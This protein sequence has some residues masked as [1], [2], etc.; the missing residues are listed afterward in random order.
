LVFCSTFFSAAAV[1]DGITKCN[2]RRYSA[3]NQGQSDFASLEL[4]AAGRSKKLLTMAFAA[5]GY[6]RV[7]AFER[8]TEGDKISVDCVAF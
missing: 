4:G 7:V 2:S 3:S 5:I 1:D 6:N 8:R